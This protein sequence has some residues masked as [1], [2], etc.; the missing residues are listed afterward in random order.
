MLFGSRK[1]K[2]E[3]DVWSLGCILVEIATGEQL[4]AGKSEL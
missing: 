4:F 1:Y 2:Y 3:V